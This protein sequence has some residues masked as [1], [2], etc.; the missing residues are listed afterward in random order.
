MAETSQ[1]ATRQIAIV[2]AANSR[3][4]DGTSDRCTGTAEQ[5]LHRIREQQLKSRPRWSIKRAVLGRLLPPN[6]DAP[7]LDKDCPEHRTIQLRKSER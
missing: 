4:G 2:Q 6:P 3:D 1:A 5:A 7:L